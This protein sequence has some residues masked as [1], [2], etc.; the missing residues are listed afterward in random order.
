MADANSGLNSPNLV[1]MS[2]S[3][4]LNATGDK[5]HFAPP[6]KCQ[7]LRV[8]LTVLDGQ[9]D[10]G[11]GTVKFD[12]VTGST[13]GDGDVATLTVPASDNDSKHVYETLASRVTLNPGDH[14]FVEVTADSWGGATNAIATI[15]YQEIPEVPENISSMVAG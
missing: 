5:A 15:I 11:G 14:V 3:I 12:K 7:I 1:W 8:G 13:R 10:A 6:I 4:D 2:A 9:T